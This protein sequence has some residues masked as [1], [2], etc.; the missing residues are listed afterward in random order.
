MHSKGGKGWFEFTE[1]DFVAYGDA[2]A[3]RFYVIPLLELK[4]RISKLPQRIVRCGNDSTGLI[5]RLS[6]IADI[7][8]VI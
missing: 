7:A 4:Q 5:V 8:K 2:Q 1:A 3:R 6:E